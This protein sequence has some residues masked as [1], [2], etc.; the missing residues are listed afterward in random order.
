MT[1]LIHHSVVNS[2]L[3]QD[4]EHWIIATYEELE[5]LLAKTA[6][7]VEVKWSSP[8]T[9]ETFTTGMLL[10]S[11]TSKLM[12]F[13]QLGVLLACGTTHICSLAHNGITIEQGIINLSIGDFVM[14]AGWPATADHIS[15]LLEPSAIAMVRSP[16]SNANNEEEEEEM[17][18]NDPNDDTPLDSEDDGLE[19]KCH[20]L[21]YRPFKEAGLPP[22]GNQ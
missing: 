19:R 18:S 13:D 12:I 9:C 1:H 8:S 21:I 7:L 16:S 15:A 11:V 2:Q 22:A 5:G 20:I 14:I 4:Q 17:I 6:V 10:P 3:P